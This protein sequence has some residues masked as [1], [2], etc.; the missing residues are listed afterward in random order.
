MGRK[1]RNTKRKYKIGV[2]L[3]STL[4]ETHAAAIAAKE[5]GYDIHNKDVT[6]WNH[7]NFPED[8]RNKIM[9]YFMDPCHMC[10][11]ARPIEKSQETIKRWSEEGHEIILITARSESLSESTIKMVNRLYPEI[12]D[13]HVVGVDQSKKSVMLSKKIDFWVDDAPHGV[14]DALSIGIPTFMVSNNYTKYNWTILDNPDIKG[15]VKTISEI[16]EFS[17]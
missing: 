13:I 7:L 2:D 16:A 1:N 11:Q 10:D 6:R 9:E 4:I 3:D 12:K 17:K 15:I 5:L 14:L 8:L